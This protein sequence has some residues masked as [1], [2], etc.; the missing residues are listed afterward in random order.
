IDMVRQHAESYHPLDPLFP[1]QWHL[2][3]RGERDSVAGVDGRVAEAWDLGF[4][5]SEVIVAVN[6]DG[7][8]VNHKDLAFDTLS[9]LNYPEDWESRLSIGA[10]GGHGTSVAGVSA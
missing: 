3:N 7:V 8:A 10:F 5:R 4:G 1:R 9:P 2:E 6:D